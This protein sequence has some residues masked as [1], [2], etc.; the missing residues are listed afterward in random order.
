LRFVPKY[1]TLRKY[2]DKETI[3][4][5]PVQCYK[6]GDFG[7]LVWVCSVNN[8]RDKVGFVVS[9]NEVFGMCELDEVV[10]Q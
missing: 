3:K 4:Y 7:Q 5:T 10:R 9:L 2:F 6:S 8:K 1:E